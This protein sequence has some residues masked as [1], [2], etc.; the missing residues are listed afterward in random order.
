MPPAIAVQKMAGFAQPGLRRIVAAL[1]GEIDARKRAHGRRRRQEQHRVGLGEPRLDA[2]QDRAAYHQRRDDRAAP[3]DERQRR[4]IGQKHRADG[5]EQRRYA[6]EPDAHLRVRQSEL[7]RGFDGGGLQPVDADGFLVANLVLEADVDE[8]AGLDHLLGRL[9]EPRLVTIDRRDVEEAGQE[10]QRA[11]DDQER[12]GPHVRCGREVQRGHE[13]AAGI[14][15]LRRLLS[16]AKPPCP[17]ASAMG[18]AL[19]RNHRCDNRLGAG[20]DLEGLG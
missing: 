7:C 4:P 2:E 8:I 3:R 14:R 19:R 6:I 1:P 20:P 9:R 10:E 15:P 17:N 11:A 12:K 18:L 16:R 5:A 13:A